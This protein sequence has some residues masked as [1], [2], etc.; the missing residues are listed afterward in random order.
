MPAVNST[1]PFFPTTILVPDYIPQSLSTFSLLT[2]FS[3]G[4]AG[5]IHSSRV[6]LWAHQPH[7]TAGENW[8]AT[9]FILCGFIHTFFEGKYISHYYLSA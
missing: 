1:H 6:L 5:I 3:V 9:W 4:L 2:I 7:L 8:T